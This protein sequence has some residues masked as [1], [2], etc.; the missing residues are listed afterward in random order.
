M[1]VL[2]VETKPA[3]ATSLMKVLVKRRD[4]QALDFR[5][6]KRCELNGEHFDTIHIRKHRIEQVGDKIRNR[7]QHRRNIYVGQETWQSPVMRDPSRGATQP[8]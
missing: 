7:V 2:C 8:I 4:F 5:A 6:L 1:T 3:D